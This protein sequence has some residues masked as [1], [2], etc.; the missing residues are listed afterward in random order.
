MGVT[1]QRMSDG[2]KKVSFRNIYEQHYSR[3][4]SYCLR[5]MNQADAGDAVADVFAVA[6]RRIEDV[7]TGEATLP[8]LYGVAYRVVSDYRRGQGRRGR[9]GV[10]L[11]GLSPTPV[12]APDSQLVQRQDYE[13]VLASLDQLRPPDQEVL[14]LAVWEELSHGEIAAA[15]NIKVATV[16]QRF[17][18]AKRALLK[19]FERTGGTVLEPPVARE[20]G[21]Q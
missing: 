7:P 21:E 11:R 14:R 15:L 1:A 20:G 2:D 9:L 8:W 19:E 6:W 18:R 5:R 12:D 4:R 17:H 13:L 3:I 10:R 16:R